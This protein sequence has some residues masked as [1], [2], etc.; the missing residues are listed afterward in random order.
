MSMDLLQV[1][2][3]PT[4]RSIIELLWAEEL[5]A[6]VIAEHFDVTF[7]AVSQHLRKL[8][9][10]QLVVVRQDGTKRL[11]RLD[12]TRLAPFRGMLEAMWTSKLDQLAALVEDT[13]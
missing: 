11:Y 7:G 2:A 6:G 1:I 3:E 4:R 5:S 8:R 12:H 9:E 13:K 10:A